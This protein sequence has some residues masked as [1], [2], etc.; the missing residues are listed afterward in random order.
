MWG[1]I[2]I[3]IIVCLLICVVAVIESEDKHIRGNCA[4]LALI[5]GIV[6]MIWVLTSETKEG[7]YKINQCEL[8]LPRNQTCKLI[9]VP[10][11]IEGE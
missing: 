8:E 11:E 2:F 5:L 3:L 6:I 7:I 1:F 4:G 9:A 10:N